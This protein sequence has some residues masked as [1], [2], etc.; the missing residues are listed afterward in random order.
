MNSQNVRKK[1]F[2]LKC[3]NCT[4][5]NYV[6][7]A[8]I[9]LGKNKNVLLKITKFKFVWIALFK[10]FFCVFTIIYAAFIITFMCGISILHYSHIL[11]FNSRVQ[12]SPPFK[13][14]KLWNI[15]KPIYIP[16]LSHP[17]LEPLKIDTCRNI[18]RGGG[19]G[20]FFFFRCF[21]F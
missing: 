1:I 4:F 15:F 13:P 10:P 6:N 16:H 12:K 2:P 5:F 19:G 7:S 9:H 20:L 8:I 11:W 21:L 17:L 3:F 14:F 18:W